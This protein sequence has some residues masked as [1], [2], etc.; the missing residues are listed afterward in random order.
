MSILELKNSHSLVN[1]GFQL[2]IKTFDLF[3][4]FK[5]MKISINGFIL[6]TVHCLK[7]AKF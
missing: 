5:L 6:K 1:E 3:P 4:D 2:K 7:N